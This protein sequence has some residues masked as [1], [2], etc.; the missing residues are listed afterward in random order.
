MFT[1]DLVF[2]FM[3]CALAISEVADDASLVLGAA[4]SLDLRGCSGL[5]VA[6]DPGSD[7][8]AALHISLD[9]VLLFGVTD[10]VWDC[11]VDVFEV[12]EAVFVCV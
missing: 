1:D 3:T 11:G 12:V 10:P 2:R 4:G 6:A 8:D 7:E 9:G 5:S